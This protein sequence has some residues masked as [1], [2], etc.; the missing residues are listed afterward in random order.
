M[1][2][3]AARQNGGEPDGPDPTEDP[4][5]YRKDEIKDETEEDGG[6]R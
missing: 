6:G 4:V 5:L 1:T 2:R 3:E